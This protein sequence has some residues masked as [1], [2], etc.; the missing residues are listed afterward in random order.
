[1]KFYKENKPEAAQHLYP[2][3]KDDIKE[4]L[5]INSEKYSKRIL[6]TSIYSEEIPSETLANLETYLRK[7][8]AHDI[9]ADLYNFIKKFLF[10]NIYKIP[11]LE[12][13]KDRIHAMY[14]SLITDID[15]K[16]INIDNLV[17]LGHEF[18]KVLDI[19][20]WKDEKKFDVSSFNYFIM[21]KL[22]RRGRI[23][24]PELKSLWFYLCNNDKFF[25]GI[26]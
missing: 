4:T 23:F 10:E 15:I 8:F 18:L 24:I 3:Y 25:S 11:A 1:M 5:S 12:N 2:F 20:A 13:S 21:T 16:N 22:G 17:D 7:V 9:D 14:K 26:F 19:T 6:G